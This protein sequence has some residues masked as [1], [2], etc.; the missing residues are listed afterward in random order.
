[1]AVFRVLHEG[2]TL[3]GLHGTVRYNSVDK[4]G[5]NSPENPRLIGVESNCGFCLNVNDRDE[6]KRLKDS[7]VMSVEANSK[8]SKNSRQSYLYEHSMIS[9]S[10]KDDEKYSLE[11]LQKL[12]LEACELYDPK[13]NETPFMLFPQTDSGKTHFHVVRGF[14]ADDGKYQRVAQSGRKMERAAQKLEKKYKLTFTGKNDPDN[15]F[16]IDGKRTYIPKH[17]QDDQKVVKNKYSSKIK[18]HKDKVNKLEDKKSVVQNDITNLTNNANNTVND[19]N[20]SISEINEDIKNDTNELDNLGFFNKLLKTDKD[21]LTENISINSRK[22]QG[23]K[24]KVKKEKRSANK[25]KESLSNKYNKLETSIDR[26]N[27]DI[28]AIKDKETKLKTSFDSVDDFKKSIND[29][30]RKNQSS[31]E[32]IEELNKLDIEIQYLHRKNGNGGITFKGNGLEL[33]GGKIN[34]MLTFG[35]IKKNNPELFKLITGQ[36]DLLSLSCDDSNNNKIN[37]KSINDNYKQKVDKHGNT[38]IYYEH[39]DEEKYPRN[40]NLKLSEDKNRISFGQR[41]NDHDIKLSYDLA[42]Q[43]GWTNACSDSKELIQKCMKVAFK[44]NPDDLFF[45]QTNEPS[46]KVD[47][48]KEITTYKTLSDDN[49]IKLYDS[50]V[51]V[52]EEKDKLK[53]YI[54]Q[55]CARKDYPVDRISDCLDK[56][57]SLKDTFEEIKSSNNSGGNNKQQLHTQS[58]KLKGKSINS[59]SP[60]LTPFNNPNHN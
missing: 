22:S 52:P 37:I 13:F 23:L 8:L 9:F 41:S 16:I 28:S 46:L 5:L 3:R 15:W 30:Y 50:G 7:F 19:L 51:V 10:E 36:S 45:F 1:M 44:E 54:I 27:G 53:S 31:K 6:Y 39:K 43:T 40:F 55:Q 58:K 21:V 29:T 26:E 47:E 48:I 12:A 20:N 17:K 38:F 49:L 2:K 60:K 56:N 4:K 14:H 18:I 42:K 33:A 35:K 24:S 57:K 59:L 34:S 11:E 32:F 25:Q